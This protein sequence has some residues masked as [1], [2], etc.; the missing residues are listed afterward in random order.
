MR[1]PQKIRNI[2]YLQDLSIL[3]DSNFTISGHVKKLGVAANHQ[4]KV[5]LLEKKS[6]RLIKATSTDADGWYIFTNLN[7]DYRYLVLSIDSKGEFNAVIQDNVV[8][9]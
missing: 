5:Y 9:K 1:I 6:M 3:T 7:K 2:Y 8:P 4:I